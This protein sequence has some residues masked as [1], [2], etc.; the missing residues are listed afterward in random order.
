AD[1]VR[2]EL[3]VAFARKKRVIPA[4]VDDAPMLS[5]ADLPESL[6]PL[7]KRNAVR[8][9][10]ERFRS[11]IDTLIGALQRILSGLAEKPITKPIESEKS[12]GSPTGANLVA[13]AKGG[14]SALADTSGTGDIEFKSINLTTR[15]AYLVVAIVAAVVLL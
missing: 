8:V 10:H 7:T 1:F 6:R 11:D 14:E 4:M 13:P 3:E 5:P 9:R 12:Q 2:L 15:R